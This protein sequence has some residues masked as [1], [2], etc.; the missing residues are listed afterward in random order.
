MNTSVLL[1][2]FPRWR[3][4]P[5]A[6][7]FIAAMVRIDGH[8]L[9]VIAGGVREPVPIPPEER[10]MPSKLVRAIADLW[11]DILLADLERRPPPAPLL[12]SGG[13]LLHNSDIGG[14]HAH[15]TKEEPPTPITQTPPPREPR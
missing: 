6:Q 4:I 11:A 7:A 13:E 3:P 2:Q 14:S 12:H 10:R 5:S 8:L 9:W 1:A 15:T